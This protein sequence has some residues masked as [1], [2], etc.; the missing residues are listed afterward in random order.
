MF[1]RKLILRFSNEQIVIKL[2]VLKAV[3]RLVAS[4][5]ISLLKLLNARALVA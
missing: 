5:S 3:R 4:R 2:F 1:L